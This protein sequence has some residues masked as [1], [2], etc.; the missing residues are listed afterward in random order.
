MTPL[1]P[2]YDYVDIIWIWGF[3]ISPLWNH[4]FLNEIKADTKRVGEELTTQ[5]TMKCIQPRGNY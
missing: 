1:I 3:T 2:K 4:S 5:P